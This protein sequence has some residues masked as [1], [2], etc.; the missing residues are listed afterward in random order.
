MRHEKEVCNVKIN[1]VDNDVCNVRR[2]NAKWRW[3][4][5]GKNSGIAKIVFVSG[6]K[7]VCRVEW[8]ACKL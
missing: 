4:C 6:K 8:I 1:D 2:K 3:G 7:S 5:S